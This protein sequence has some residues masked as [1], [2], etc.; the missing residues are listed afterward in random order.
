M[1]NLVFCT[2]YTVHNSGEAIFLNNLQLT[3]ILTVNFNFIASF[4]SVDSVLIIQKK[5]LKTYNNGGKNFI[6]FSYKRK[7]KCELP[8]FKV[9]KHLSNPNNFYVTQSALSFVSHYEVTKV[10]LIPLSKLLNFCHQKN[11]NPLT[12]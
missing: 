12:K 5:N 7:I 9:Y 10:I 8:K 4:L 2:R 3:L 11:M 1:R 6:P